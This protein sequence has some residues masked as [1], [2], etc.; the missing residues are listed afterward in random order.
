MPKDHRKK[1]NNTENSY[2]KWIDQETM[3]NWWME[4]GRWKSDS[5]QTVM[6]E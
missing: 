3:F 5:D 1:K 4:E 6:F 2:T